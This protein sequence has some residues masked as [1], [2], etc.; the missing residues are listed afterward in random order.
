MNQ[1]DNLIEPLRSYVTAVLA[2]NQSAPD[3]PRDLFEPLIRYVA[4]RRAAQQ[5]IALDFICTHNSRRSHLA[6]VWADTATKFWDIRGI[7]C[8]SG[9]VETTACNERTIGTLRRAG[10]SIVR[11][12][13][14]GEKTQ[15]NQE[16]NG[17]AES[18][19]IYRL[20]AFE[21]EPAISL[22][23]K[24]YAEDGPPSDFVAMMCCADVDQRCPVI[25][26]AVLRIP[27]HYNDPKAADGTPEES[28]TYD[29]RCVQIAREMFW[30]MELLR[31]L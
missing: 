27:L 3:Q 11:E 18:N 23:S 21:S 8:Y 15:T 17:L 29:E 19:P 7:D 30:L 5:P 10:F 12:Q 25:N 24:V 6:H 20:Q 22:Y 1:L 26:D 31:S 28:A 16:E 4:Q 2:D 13:K 14:N 9:G